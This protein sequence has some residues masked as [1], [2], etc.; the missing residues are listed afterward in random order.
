MTCPKC[1][2]SE[3]VS[4]PLGHTAEKICDTCEVS[5]KRVYKNLNVGDITEDTMFHIAE[6]MRK[7]KSYSGEDR[8]VF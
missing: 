7:A 1:G 3:E 2:K 4:F 6:M 8:L 5:M